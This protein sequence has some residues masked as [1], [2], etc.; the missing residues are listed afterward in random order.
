MKTQSRKRSPLACSPAFSE[1][2]ADLS[3][4]LWRLD[5][6]GYAVRTINQRVGGRKTGMVSRAHREVMRRVH[7]PLTPEDVVDHI[8]FDKLDNRRENLRVGSKMANSQHRQPM[9]A[10]GMRGVTFV[11]RLRKWQASVGHLGKKYYCGLFLTPESAAE[12][13]AAKRE[14]LG[15]SGGGG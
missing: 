3:R 13:A 6:H 7:G 5:T 11:K 2:D 12:A 1:E 14:E 10:I 15:F 9:N 4:H 8:N